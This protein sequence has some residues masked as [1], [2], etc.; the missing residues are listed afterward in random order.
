MAAFAEIDS[1]NVVLRVLVADSNDVT[2]NGGDQSEAAATHFQSLVGLSKNGVKYVQTSEDG[3]FRKNFA[4]PTFTYDSSRD[5]F[6]PV[7][8]YPSW[9]LDEATCRYVPPVARPETFDMH[10]ADATYVDAEGNPEKDRYWWNEE[11]VSWDFVG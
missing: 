11:T 3:S 6:I 7:K 2:N 1:N 8:K 4:S 10:A 5:A 9:V